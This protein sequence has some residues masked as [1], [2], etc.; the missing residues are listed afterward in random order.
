MYKIAIIR[1]GQLGS[2]HLQG[3]KTANQELA[4]EVI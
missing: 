2:R 4:I 3:I 1:A